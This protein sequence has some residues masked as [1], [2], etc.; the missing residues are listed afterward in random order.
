MNSQRRAFFLI[1]MLAVLMAVAVGGGLMAVG[2]T[3][4]IR[5][6]RRVVEFGN[7]YTVLDGFLQRLRHDVRHA[8]TASLQ[9]SEEEDARQTL[10]IGQPPHQVVYR[11]FDQHVTRSGAEDDPTPQSQWTSIVAAIE[12]SAGVSLADGPLITVSASYPNKDQRDPY[13]DRVFHLSVR[14]ARKLPHVEP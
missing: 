13:P 11:F 14:C 2:I 7:R 9:D 6:Q 8:R 4:I 12:L 3:S 10:A 5:A 1:E